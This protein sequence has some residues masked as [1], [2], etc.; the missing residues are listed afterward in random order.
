M[1]VI[2]AIDLKEDKVVRLLKGNFKQKTVYSADPVNTA[3][4]WQRQGAKYL[5]VVDLDGAKL[6]K[7][8]HL[9]VVKK[10]IKNVKIPVEFGGGL[11]NKRIIKQVLDCGVE[12][13]VLGTKLQDENFLR[14]AFKEF[15]H[16]IIVSIDADGNTIQLDG[17][18]R[19]YKNPSVLGF[20]RK[21]EDIGFKQIIYTDI[22]RDG[23]LKG[24]NIAMIKRILKSSGLG[25]IA[26]GGISALN[27]LLKLKALTK[28]GLLGVI[29]GK[30]LYEGKFTLREAMK[31]TA[32]T[33]RPQANSGKM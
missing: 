31:E 30:A 1:L 12:R 21:L 5:H 7:V 15:K 17:W 9:E 2:P 14:S 20:I 19:T 16:K 4:H 8:C 13:V 10:I 11:R 6:G 32:S 18:Q 23:T 28:N 29:I 24:I 26:S 33:S 25:L 27:D 3:R 22:S